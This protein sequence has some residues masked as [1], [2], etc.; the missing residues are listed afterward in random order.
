MAKEFVSVVMGSWRE[1]GEASRLLGA[2]EHDRRVD[3]MEAVDDTDILVLHLEKRMPKTLYIGHLC[4][5]SMYVIN[6]LEY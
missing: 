1:A 2:H 5:P 4:L 3:F 6:F